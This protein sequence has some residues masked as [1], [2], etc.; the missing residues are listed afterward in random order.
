MTYT[1]VIGNHNYSSWSLRGWLYLRESG[2]DFELVRL[3]LFTDDWQERIGLYS[4]TR[5]VP[6]LLDYGISESGASDDAVTVWDSLA[7]MAYLRE[8]VPGALGWPAEPAARAEALSIAAEMHSGFL[9]LR[10]ELP[11]NIRK[12][13]PIPL[14]AF[15]EVAQSQ[16]ARVIDIWSGCR[17]RYR[18]RG[19]WLFGSMCIADI[20]YAPVALRFVTYGIPLP[21]AAQ[22]FVDAVVALPSIQEW[23]ALAAA[24][25]ETLDFIDDLVPANDSPLTSG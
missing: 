7:I 2:I 20:L 5:R 10:D 8:Q 24:E 21:E 23:Q 3:P 25:V 19:P 14:D 22:E 17:S 4:P 6:V 12:T 13:R 15:S 9:A 11:Q 18:D 16:I 1:L